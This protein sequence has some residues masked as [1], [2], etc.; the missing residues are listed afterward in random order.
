MPYEPGTLKAI[1]AKGGTTV[2]TQEVKIADTPAKIILK[3]DRNTIHTN[4]DDLSF[5]TVITVDKDGNIVPDANNLI[6]YN[7]NG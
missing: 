1:S 2:L 4:G 3:A 5:I 6:R 7:I